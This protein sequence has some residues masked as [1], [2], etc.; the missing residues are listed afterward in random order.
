MIN[1]LCIVKELKDALRKEHPGVG[2]LFS[3]FCCNNSSV[4]NARK[5]KPLVSSCSSTLRLQVDSR[6]T[7]GDGAKEDQNNIRV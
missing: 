5:N 3:S 2:Q 4:I 6:S 1:F 7:S